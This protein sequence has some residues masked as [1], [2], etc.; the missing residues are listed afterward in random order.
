M[1]RQTRT[2]VAAAWKLLPARVDG[3]GRFDLRKVSRATAN[4]FEDTDMTAMQQQR[5]SDL[6]ELMSAEYIELP[7]LSLTKPQMRRLWG[8]EAV[9]C[10]ALVDALVAARVLWKTPTGTYVSVRAPAVDSAHGDL[11]APSA[12]SLRPRQ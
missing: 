9:V 12:R 2:K 1:N 4:L 6:C 8:L 10:D 5:M 3:Q 11:H 7:G